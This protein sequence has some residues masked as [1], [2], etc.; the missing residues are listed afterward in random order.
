MEV[1]IMK[2]KTLLTLL[3]SCLFSVSATLIFPMNQARLA[4]DQEV[5][6]LAL[7]IEE[8]EEFF[9]LL[10]LK[11]Q[12]NDFLKAKNILLAQRLKIEKKLDEDI[13]RDNLKTEE[14]EEFRAIIEEFNKL[15]Q[16]KEPLAWQIPALIATTAIPIALD[17]LKN[18]EKSFLMQN[19]AHFAT[20]AMARYAAIYGTCGIGITL[21]LK[22]PQIITGSVN[23]IQSTITTS[24]N[25]KL[26]VAK[27][28]MLFAVI[29]YANYLTRGKDSLLAHMAQHGC[30]GI[31]PSTIDQFGAT[32]SYT[33]ELLK[34]I[35]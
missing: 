33:I 34:P 35:N 12:T 27:A 3:F 9:E 20:P 22:Y 30:A 29:L 28:S 11:A 17:A 32:I 19:L 2:N 10:E 5:K 14:D 8:T 23:G 7:K 6:R 13:A 18:K 1:I 4:L 24:W 26:I 15:P 25:N 31:I 16:K 21:G